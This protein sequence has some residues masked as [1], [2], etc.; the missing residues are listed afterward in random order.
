MLDEEQRYGHM[1][2]WESTSRGVVEACGV[3]IAGVWLFFQVQHISALQ[4]PD[5]A[6]SN[7]VQSEYVL[8]VI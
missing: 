2:L 7:Q 4:R 8:N 5:S 3:R 1:A 6:L